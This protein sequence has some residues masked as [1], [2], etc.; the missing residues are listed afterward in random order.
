MAGKPGDYSTEGWLF[1]EP[2]YAVALRSHDH[3]FQRQAT[4]TMSW[5]LN[6]YLSPSNVIQAAVS[7]PVRAKRRSFPVQ[8]ENALACLSYVQ[9]RAPVSLNVGIV[10]SASVTA[11]L[12]SIVGDDESAERYDAVAR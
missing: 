2:A 12:L 6:W 1:F 5:F 9:S 7:S 3:A 10:V 4:E 11:K 8:D